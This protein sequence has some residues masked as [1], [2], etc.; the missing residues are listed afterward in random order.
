MEF[1]LFKEV[2]DHSLDALILQLLRSL[3]RE[4]FQAEVL[5]VHQQGNV[6]CVE[7]AVLRIFEG[8][9]ALALQMQ[10]AV[11]M[12]YRAALNTLEMAVL[13]VHEVLT[14]ST[15]EVQGTLQGLEDSIVEGEVLMLGEAGAEE[16]VAKEET[17]KV[18]IGLLVALD[19]FLHSPVLQTHHALLLL[20]V[21]V[22]AL[23]TPSSRFL[24]LL[25]S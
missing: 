14:D 10:S 3:T 13:N 20:R 12:C 25:F 17:R 5:H 15:L 9:K 8:L 24:G 23:W 6:H 18:G 22:L 19:F 7:V 1:P 4:L 2:L 21:L 11:Y 16:I